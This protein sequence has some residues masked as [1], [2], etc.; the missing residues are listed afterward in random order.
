MGCCGNTTENKDITMGSGGIAFQGQENED[1]EQQQALTPEQ[2]EENR[3]RVEQR[4]QELG[5]FQ[6]G[7]D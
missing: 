2:I 3:Q 6:F 7:T 1:M 4:K 5:D